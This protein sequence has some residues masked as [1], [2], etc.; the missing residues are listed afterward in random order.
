MK[1][2][3]RKRSSRKTKSP[4]RNQSQFTQN[5]QPPEFSEDNY[6]SLRHIAFAVQDP[7]ICAQFCVECLDMLKGPQT[8]DF[9][10][11]GMRW[12]EGRS[13]EKHPFK[14]HFVPNATTKNCYVDVLNR[15]RVLINGNLDVWTQLMDN[16]ICIG[17][18]N[19]VK[20]I[21]RIVTNSISN[22][23]K[24]WYRDNVP[25]N[26]G[27]VPYVGPVSR[28]DGIYQFYAM[29]PFGIIVEIQQPNEAYTQMKHLPVATTWSN[30]RPEFINGDLENISTRDVEA[31]IS[32]VG[33]KSTNFSFVLTNK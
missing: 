11:S 28:K 3:K 9:I 31:K 16:H 25:G 26:V 21:D 24:K 33:E 10:D 14:L 13:K 18:K 4:V 8:H 20:C 22:K 6:M 27:S 12:V 5:E 7:S 19:A 1:S 29:M 23:L 2:P 15:M 17:Y 32:E 30:L